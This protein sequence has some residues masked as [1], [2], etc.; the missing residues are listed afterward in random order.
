MKTGNKPLSKLFV[1]T[2]SGAV[3]KVE[4]TNKKTTVKKIFAE[5][6]KKSK[7]KVGDEIFPEGKFVCLTTNMGLWKCQPDDGKKFPT[8][9]GWSGRYI[10]TSPINGLFFTEK[11]AINYCTYRYNNPHFGMEEWYELPND[12]KNVLE[13]I[14]KD[15]PIIILSEKL[16]LL[17]KEVDI[18][19]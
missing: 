14:G 8:D 4:Y 9:Y 17:I 15:H 12:T 11:E 3:Y 10:G 13:K 6:P 19:F 1:T 7:A 2:V 16:L 18:P 5:D